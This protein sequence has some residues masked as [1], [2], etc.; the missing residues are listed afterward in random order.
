MAQKDDDRYVRLIYL[1]YCL[2]G[3][4]DPMIDAAIRGDDPIVRQIAEMIRYRLQ[5]TQGTQ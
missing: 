1:L 3:P 4:D 5:R 2:E